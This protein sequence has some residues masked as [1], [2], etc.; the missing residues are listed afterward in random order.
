MALSIHESVSWAGRRDIFL[1]IIDSRTAKLEVL[2]LLADST[3][4]L[5]AIASP[6]QA[7]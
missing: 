5:V 6:Q 4:I 7:C 1:E 3:E 2:I